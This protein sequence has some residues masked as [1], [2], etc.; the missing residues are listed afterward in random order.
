MCHF[1]NLWKNSLRKHVVKNLC[2]RKRYR[3]SNHGNELARQATV[4][5]IRF[6]DI[7]AEFGHLNVRSIDLVKIFPEYPLLG[8]DWVLGHRHHQLLLLL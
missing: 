6:F 5:G 2:Q 7:S 3:R 1:K 4:R 8:E